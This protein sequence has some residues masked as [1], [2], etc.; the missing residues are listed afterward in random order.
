MERTAVGDGDTGHEAEKLQESISDW[1]WFSQAR[2][3]DL[4][5]RFFTNGEA[6]TR[7]LHVG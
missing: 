5:D 4:V 2:L 3:V 1:F 6:A 7:C